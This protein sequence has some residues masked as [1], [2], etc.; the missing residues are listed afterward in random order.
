MKQTKNTTMLHLGG[1]PTEPDVRALMEDM[2]K[3]AYTEGTII[4]KQDVE[5]IISVQANTFRFQTVVAAWR[6]RLMAEWNIILVAVP[7][8][9]WKVASPSER[10]SLSVSKVKS[11]LRHVRRGGT[12]ATTTDR[13]RLKPEE[14]RSADHIANVCAAIELTAKTKARELRL[15][16]PTISK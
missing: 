4:K 14:Q 9:G 16:V 12:I 5:G 2:T 7:G 6:K 10:I 3:D 8:V 15:P 11:G 13:A 1:I